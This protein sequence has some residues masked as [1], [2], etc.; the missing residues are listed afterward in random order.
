MLFDCRGFLNKPIV[1]VAQIGAHIGDEIPFLLSLAPHVIAFEPQSH[2]FEALKYKTSPF[3]DRVTCIQ[4]A[5]GSTSGTATMYVEDANRSM[6]SSLLKPKLHLT[7]YPH[8]VFNRQETVTV[9]T[10]DTEM[11]GRPKVNM[12]MIDAQ[13]YELEILK[14]GRETLKDVDYIYTEVNRDEVYEGCPNVLVLDNYLVEFKFQRIYTSWDGQTW[15]DAIY[16]KV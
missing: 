14:G 7:Q 2:V 13:G 15:G 6:S 1:G 10:L 16:I 5:L 8:I 4:K 12:L 11:V 9:S 3:G